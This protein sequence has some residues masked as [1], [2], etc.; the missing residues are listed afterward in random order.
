[1]PWNGLERSLQLGR[2]KQIIIGREDSWS[3][4]RDYMVRGRDS[5]WSWLL[6]YKGSTLGRQRTIHTRKR[7]VHRL[8]MGWKH[9]WSRLRRNMPRLGVCCASRLADL[10]LHSRDTRGRQESIDLRG[11]CR[12]VLEEVLQ[13]LL[14]YVTHLSIQPQVW[15]GWPRVPRDAV[16][17]RRGWGI[18]QGEGLSCSSQ[19]TRGCARHKTTITRRCSRH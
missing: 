14:S 11:K 17:N 12:D 13:V 9:S 2:H 5:S 8:L 7:L 1:M 4:R 10:L 19:V 18:H 16:G 15:D 3:R 6:L